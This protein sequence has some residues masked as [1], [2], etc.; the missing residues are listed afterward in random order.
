MVREREET[1]RERESV[2][3]HDGTSVMVEMNALIRPIFYSI[4]TGMMRWDGSTWPRTDPE[5]YPQKLGG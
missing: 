5:I 1:R 3:I 2:G 4:L